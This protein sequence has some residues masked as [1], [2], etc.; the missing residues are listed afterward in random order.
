MYGIFPYIYH[1]NQSHGS[2]GDMNAF[3]LIYSFSYHKSPQ[4]NLSA[5][6]IFSLTFDHCLLTR[7]SYGTDGVS[8]KSCREKPVEEKGVVEIY[9]LFIQ[10]LKK[11]HP[12]GHSG[13]FWGIFVKASTGCHSGQITITDRTPPIKVVSKKASMGPPY[14]RGKPV[15]GWN[16]IHPFWA[17]IF[18]R[19]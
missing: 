8:T 2:F 1:K 18:H 4:H 7:R 14:F 10:G 16:E 15:G 13:C 5:N 12:N 6:M 11:V 3:F 17:D 9:P 19:V